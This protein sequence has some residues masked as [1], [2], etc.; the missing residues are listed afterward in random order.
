MK[1]TDSQIARAKAK[2]NAMLVYKTVASYEPEYIGWAAAEQRCEFHN[3]IV[4]EILNGNKET[5]RT[6]KLFFLNE[7]IKADRKE[8]E[9]KA[10]KSANKEASSDLLAS[11]KSAGKLLGDYYKWLNTA[12]N[13]Y[14]KEYFSRKYSAESVNSFLSI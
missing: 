1:A 12:G 10:K 13:Q 9:S 3:R 8:A 4:S 2:Y 11:I 6:W 14:R 7:E 5:E